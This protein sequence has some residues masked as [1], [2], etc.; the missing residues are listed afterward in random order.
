MLKELAKPSASWGPQEEEH[1]AEFLQGIIDRAN[2]VDLTHSINANPATPTPDALEAGQGVNLG[3]GA[4][5]SP[6]AALGSL[7]AEGE[8]FQSK[9]S[10]A[11]RLAE[12]HVR[13]LAKQGVDAGQIASS[14]VA[15]EQTVSGW[16]VEGGS[17][18]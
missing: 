3:S 12:K 6:Q 15:L 10:L 16:L 18:F 11:G 5:F 1:R 2:G 14:A 7:M 9:L 13:E 4:V 17:I 8:F